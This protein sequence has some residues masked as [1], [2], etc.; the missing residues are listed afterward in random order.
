MYNFAI[1]GYGNLGKGV[2]KA[3]M[4]RDDAQIVGVFTR[5]NPDTVHTLG[6]NVYHLDDILDFK[7]EI[8]LCIICGGSANDLPVQ[9]P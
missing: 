4:K 3:L 6:T 9:T 8:D 5:R 2:E 1:V 7:E